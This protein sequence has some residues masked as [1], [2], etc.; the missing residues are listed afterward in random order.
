MI[1][2]SDYNPI[3][4][5]L[6]NHLMPFSALYN[7][8]LTRK[9]SITHLFYFFSHFSSHLLC[10]IKII[11]TLS[12]MIY[13]YEYKPIEQ[14]QSNYLTPFSAIQALER[15]RH[16]VFCA[17]TPLLFPIFSHIFYAFIKIITSLSHMIYVDFYKLIGQNQSNHLAPFS[18]I[19][20]RQMP[21]HKIFCK[22]TPFIFPH[23][24]FNY[25]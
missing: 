22:Y 21:R 16:K 12:H 23:F 13:M 17:Y 20:E 14:R 25:L 11:T 24:V 7:H 9:M 8:C 5:C 19:Q 18:A 3:D 6:S 1:N 4:N 2:L 10:F 15:P